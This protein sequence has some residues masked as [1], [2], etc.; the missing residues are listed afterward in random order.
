MKIKCTMGENIYQGEKSYHLYHRHDKM[1]DKPDLILN[2]Y[3]IM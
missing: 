1:W 2:G 3:K